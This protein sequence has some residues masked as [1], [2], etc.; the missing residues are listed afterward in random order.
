MSNRGGYPGFLGYPPLAQ[1]R[2]PGASVAHLRAEIAEL[3][4]R[5]EEIEEEPA[6]FGVVL[7]AGEARCTVRLGPQ[8]LDLARPKGMKGVEPGASVRLR[9][10]RPAILG[11]ADV[12]ALG[13]VATVVAIIDDARCE[14]EAFGGQARAVLYLGERPKP[15]DR[16]VLDDGSCVALSNI[17]KAR[18]AQTYH[19]ETGVSWDDVGGLVEAKRQLR[20]AVEEP[21][22]HP[23]LYAKFGRA[24]TKGILLH[25]PP[26]CGKTLLGKAVASS[27]ARLH[28]SKGA[29]SGF[30]YVKG[31]ELLNKYIGASE[32]NVRRLFSQA[33]LHQEEHGY[34]ACVFI[35]EAD[36][37]LGRRGERHGVEGMER[38]L[39]P[40]FL[41]EMDGF[42]DAACLMLLATNRPDALDSA[43]VREGRIDRKVLVGRPSRDDVAQILERALGSRPLAGS[44]R[45][46]AGEGADALFS[47]ELALYVVR[48]KDGEERRVCLRHFAS[49]ALAVAAAELAAQLAIRRARTDGKAKIGRDDLVAAAAQLLEEQ[50]AGDHAE[51]LADFVEP[52]RGEVVD[53]V[54][55]PKVT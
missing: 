30:L 35:D 11:V 10:G 31:P 33:R 44:A 26:G 1:E 22:E 19:G 48:T 4:A 45:K 42:D 28:G 3:R 32:E 2:A 12:P 20:E 9:A 40:M 8:V 52:F 24:P 41:A 13:G 47:P 51:V 36:A 55:C 21:Y 54:R 53:V 7:T 43:V 18:S 6:L 38:T 50:R 37:V 34:P 23:E 49:G 17:G 15:G 39:V 16:V 46:L 27:L 25:G 29:G 14:V 5:L